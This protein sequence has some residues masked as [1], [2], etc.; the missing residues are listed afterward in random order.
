[1]KEKEL[2]YLETTIVSYLMAWLSRDLIR[3]A[4]Q[5]NYAGVVEQSVRRFSVVRFRSEFVINEALAGG[6]EAT[7]KRLET[8]DGIALL[9]VNSEVE[10]L[11]KKSIARRFAR[12][13]NC[14]EE[15][16]TWNDEIVEEGRCVRQEYAA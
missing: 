11:A 10:N 2:V 14:L 15:N 4:H 1:M 5:P 16:M 7:E 6:A 12:P 3:A 9:D 8:L 13:K